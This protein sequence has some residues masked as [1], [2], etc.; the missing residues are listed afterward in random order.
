MAKFATISFVYC[1]KKRA[2]R[3]ISAGKAILESATLPFAS[4]VKTLEE[5][6]PG[7]AATS[8]SPMK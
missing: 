4:I 1:R 6:P 5:L 7:E 8:I 3:S 2:A